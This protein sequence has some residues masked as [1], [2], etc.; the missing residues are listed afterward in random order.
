MIVTN[1]RR[2]TRA[3]PILKSLHWL[4]VKYRSMFKVATFVYKFLTYNHPCYFSS[5][6]VPY[7]CNYNTRRSRTDKKF[8]ITPQYNPPEHRSKK[9]FNYTLA[10]DAAA[11]WNNLPENIRTAPSCTSFRKGSNPTFSTWLS[12]HS[13]QIYIRRLHW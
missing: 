3:S 11:I 12:H 7:N 13:L 1:Q 2:F 5:S 6:F 9:Q 10:F 8:L 4:P